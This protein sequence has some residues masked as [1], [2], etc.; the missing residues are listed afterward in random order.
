M[1]L[2]L[3]PLEKIR[4]PELDV[5]ASQDFAGL[6][7]LAD[8][9]KDIGLLQAPTVK[10]AGDGFEIV[11]GNRRR[12]ACKMLG[13]AAIKCLVLDAEDG[14]DLVAMRLH[15]NIVR[16]DMTPV[17]EAAVYAELFEQ[18]GDI[19]KVAA[20]CHR[21]RELVERR[22][23]L[24][25]GDPGVRDALHEGKIVLTVAEEL[26]QVRDEGTRAYLLR[27]AIE[28]GVTAETARAWRREYA[29]VNLSEINAAQPP[30]AAGVI[31][32]VGPNP[33]VCWL[34]GS[35]EEPSDMRVKMVHQSCERMWR[36][37][38]AQAEEAVR[39]G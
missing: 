12:L 22:L 24:L 7:E 14:G 38:A 34:C 13:L 4:G 21:T 39:N 5:R 8:S 18:A 32:P 10:P 20:M 19:D 6:Q 9:I 2:E 33:Y 17:E 37:R 36:N 11:T 28:S 16:K 23:A 27:H 25:S 30:S 29:H 31:E 15:E 35:D 26:N 1:R 3:I